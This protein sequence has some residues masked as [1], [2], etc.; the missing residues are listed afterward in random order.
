M[1]PGRRLWTIF[2]AHQLGRLAAFGDQ[3]VAALDDSD[4][5]V[6][7]PVYSVREDRAE[8]P[9]DL[10]T[11]FDASLREGRRDLLSFGSLDEAARELPAHLAPGDVCLL[12]GAGD[13]VRLTDALL[14]RLGSGRER[15]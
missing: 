2:Q 9:A 8:F 1:F 10:E 4:R 12:L 14:E 5:L 3:F 6:R 11:R 15:V 13:V 7:L